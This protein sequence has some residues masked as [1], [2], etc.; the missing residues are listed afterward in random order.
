MTTVATNLLVAVAV[1]AAV[2]GR[3]PFM[4][5]SLNASLIHVQTSLS[6]LAVAGLL[7][8]I[9]VNERQLALHEVEKARDGLEEVVRERTAELAQLASHDDL[10]G[11]ANRRA[12]VEALARAVSQAARGQVTTLLYGD[13]NGF[14]DCN[15][16]RGHSFGDA[17][18]IEV[19]ALLERLRAPGRLRRP[20]RR[21]RVRPA[22][23]R[24][25][26]G[27]GFPGR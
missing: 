15:D 2:E 18:L 11:L 26:A 14:K 10:T 13:L 8:G 20:R 16:T 19:A 17:I 22:A 1:V 9:I 27:R 7:L 6:C 12:F 25:W 21:R 23:R 24:D 4:H 3:G 5:G